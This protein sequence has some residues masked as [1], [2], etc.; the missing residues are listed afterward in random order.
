MSQ[1]DTQKDASSEPEPVQITK[2]D[3]TQVKNALDDEV[4]RVRP[5]I[6]HAMA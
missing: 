1:Q 3:G 2:Y 5:P 6:G 4:R